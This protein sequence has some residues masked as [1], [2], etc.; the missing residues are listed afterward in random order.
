MVKEYTTVSVP[1][2][3][4]E[5]INHICKCAKGMKH[6]KF[7]EEL[8]AE[9]YEASSEYN[10]MAIMYTGERGKLQIHF[11]GKS[12]LILGSFQMPMDATDEEVDK[13][14]KQEVESELDRKRAE[15]NDAE[16]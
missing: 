9:I 14:V 4:L 5:Q 16:D 8:I 3:T 10:K 12:D 13:R 11:I 2:E 6:S 7:L 1:I 15:E